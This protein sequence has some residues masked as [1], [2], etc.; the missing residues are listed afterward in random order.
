[1]SDYQILDG[2]VTL[3]IPYLKAGIR[4]DYAVNTFIKQKPSVICDLEVAITPVNQRVTGES[5]DMDSG[6]VVIHKVSGV[7]YNHHLF[8][9][10]A[11][12]VTYC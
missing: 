4:S 1:M 11:L 10:M 8:V 9:L 2:F 5:V 3:M 7:C 12:S 6:K